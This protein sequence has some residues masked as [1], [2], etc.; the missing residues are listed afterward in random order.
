MK[1]NMIEPK[2]NHIQFEKLKQYILDNIQKRKTINTN[3]TSYWYKHLFEKELGFYISNDDCKEAL[4]E[5]GFRPAIPTGS[6]Y[7][8]FN[9]SEKCLKDKN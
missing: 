8:Y 4:C 1:D 3:H 5:C 2:L 9:I 7:W 6:Q